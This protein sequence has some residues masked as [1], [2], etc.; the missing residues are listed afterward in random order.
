[1]LLSTIGCSEVTALKSH[2]DTEKVWVFAQ[3][4]VIEEKDVLDTYYYYGEISKS[5]YQLIS[6]NKLNEG[7]IL[8]EG[9]KYWGN[10]DLIHNYKDGENSGDLVFRIEHLAKLDLINVAPVIGKGIEQF[11]LPDTD[12]ENDITPNTQQEGNLDNRV[13]E[14][15]TSSASQTITE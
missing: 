10:D 15:L 13:K 7:F 12:K 2:A 3:F 11:E 6:E 4:N 1:M 5:L 14:N 9:V 8:L